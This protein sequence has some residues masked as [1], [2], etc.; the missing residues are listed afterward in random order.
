MVGVCWWRQG[1]K[2]LFMLCTSGRPASHVTDYDVGGQK[3]EEKAKAQYNRINTFTLFTLQRDKSGGEW[4]MC[5]SC[6]W[7]R[8]NPLPGSSSSTEAPLGLPARI[9]SLHQVEFP[10]S[11]RAQQCLEEVCAAGLCGRPYRGRLSKP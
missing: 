6:V 2:C 3:V 8:G 10:F 9:F 1:G 4:R 5:T 11:V 7:Q